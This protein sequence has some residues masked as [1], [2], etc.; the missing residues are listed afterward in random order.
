MYFSEPTQKG[1]CYS[2]LFCKALGSY[3]MPE[4]PCLRKDR[5]QYLRTMFIKAQ[6]SLI[7]IMKTGRISNEIF[8]KS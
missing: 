1:C 2:V 5:L 6:T 3:N 7:T 4:E 8:F